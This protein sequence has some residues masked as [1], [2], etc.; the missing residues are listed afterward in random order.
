M[1]RI[2]TPAAALLTLAL[3]AAGCGGG[4]SSAKDTAP[5]K[6]QA[7]A[8]AT[9]IN[10]TKADVAADLEAS[11]HDSS[12]DSS[13]K[14]VEKEVA[15]CIGVDQKVL[16]DTNTIS[17]EYSPDFAKGEPPSGYQINSDVKVVSSKDVAKKQL[18]VY[19]D[20]KTADC[21]SSAFD[22][23]FKKTLG[24]EPGATL[25]KVTIK[26]LDADAAGTDGAFAFEV[27]LPISGGGLSLDV[28]ARIYGFLVKHT[29]VTLTTASFGTDI[30]D[31]VVKG[32]YSKLVERAKK[33]AV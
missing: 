17:D 4:S 19:Q 16:D 24:S 12:D 10:L 7:T 22:K 25:G 33:S 15:T 9:A 26:K 23:E 28:K 1:T 30:P 20:S 27:S 11:D 32:A 13:D 8:A 6:A 29:E 5:T 18:A 2:G 3:L 14:A 31:D 21:L